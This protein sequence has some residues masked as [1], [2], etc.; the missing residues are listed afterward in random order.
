MMNRRHLPLLAAISLVACQTTE[1]EPTVSEHFRAGNYESALAL[2]QT[3]VD[4][5][6]DD[7]YYQGVERM[8][9][10]G[11]KLDQARDLVFDNEH[12]KALELLFEADDL[13]PGHPVVAEWIEKV[14][15]EL[16]DG[17][18]LQAGQALMDQEFDRAVELYERALVFDPDD[19]RAKAGIARSLILVNHRAGMGEQYYIEGVRSLREYWLGQANAEF[20]YNGKFAPDDKRGAARRRQVAG[21]LAEDRVLMASDFEANGLFHA[22]RNEYRIALIFD[23]DNTNAAEGL[24]RMEREVEAFAQLSEAERKRIRG[25]YADAAK[26]LAEGVELS[27]A[28][29]AE[30]ASA[31]IDLDEA[32][33][34]E[35]Y[36]EA[37]DAEADGRYERAVKLF[38]LLLQETGYY[39]DAVARRRT[40]TDMI[41]LAERLY[42]ESMAA[43]REDV[44]RQKLEQIAV[45]W[46]EYKNV[47]KLLGTAP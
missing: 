43:K 7:P 35:Q 47:G 41:D 10:V 21:L 20:A 19:E 8:A 33:W 22:A 24:A 46:P 38:D 26:A 14:V 36:K 2:A 23:E 37:L 39:E 13:A 15:G 4:D 18:L 29:V 27:E 16:T 32:R 34:K 11:L 45:F 42:S 6:P 3:Q 12:A 5:A 30:F 31:K 25:E 28:Q 17:T 40:L 44:K 1:E 9:E